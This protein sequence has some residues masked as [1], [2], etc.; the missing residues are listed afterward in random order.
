MIP[1]LFDLL[2]FLDLQAQCRVYL[3]L[4]D[5][6]RSVNLSCSLSDIIA[7]EIR[8]L[9]NEFNYQCNLVT[10]LCRCCHN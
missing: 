3:F 2:I 7:V 10:F 8:I 6:A 1:S 5:L 4:T 9:L